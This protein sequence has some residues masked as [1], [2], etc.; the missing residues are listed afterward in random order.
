MR[1]KKSKAFRVVQ[2]RIAKEVER[3]EMEQHCSQHAMEWG[4]R[5]GYAGTPLAPVGHRG[6]YEEE[7][8]GICREN[9]YIN[10]K[11]KG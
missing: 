10:S 4:R 5:P 6:D 8:D 7:Q 3:E 11:D 1:D 9:E 2:Q